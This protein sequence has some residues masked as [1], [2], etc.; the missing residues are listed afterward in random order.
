M[1]KDFFD[2][3]PTHKTVLTTNHRPI[4]YGTDEGIWRRIHYIESKM[5][6]NKN[7]KV[8]DFREKYLYPELPGILNWALK[9]LQEYLRIGLVPPVSVMAAGAQYRNDMDAIG[10][11]LEQETVK[12]E[13]ASEKM[14]A[15]YDRYK[16]WCHREGILPLGSRKFNDQLRARGYI[17]KA[18]AGNVMMVFK[19]RLNEA[20]NIF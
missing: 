19:L 11:F 6:I 12:G 10:H 5:V 13:N 14:H 18:G 2:F 20:P 17:V 7:D 15:V 8:K 16:S 4:I 9:G 1:Y 3:M